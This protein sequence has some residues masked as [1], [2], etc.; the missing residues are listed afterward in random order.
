M[1]I[2]NNLSKA[3]AKARFGLHFTQ[4]TFLNITFLCH[5]HLCTPSQVPRF[6]SG[7]SGCGRMSG[8]SGP[9]CVTC[10]STSRMAEP[11]SSGSGS[12]RR[13]K[14]LAVL[15]T[16]CDGPLPGEP[17]LLSSHLSS[18]NVEMKEAA[19]YI[20]EHLIY[21]SVSVVFLVILMSSCS[22]MVFCLPLSLSL[23]RCCLFGWN[24]SFSNYFTF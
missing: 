2:L 4:H 8:G 21:T 20:E 16:Q 7:W 10:C 17:G 11:A 19:I 12:R 14:S 9:C 1:F 5:L 6:M 22:R 24:P 18:G 23:F 3:A 15:H 13:C